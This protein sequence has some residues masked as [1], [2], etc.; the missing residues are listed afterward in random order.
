KS[1]A[2]PRRNRSQPWRPI[3]PDS[4]SGR[5][6]TPPRVGSWG[7]KFTSTTRTVYPCAFRCR[8]RGTIRPTGRSA[9]AISKSKE[10][11]T[12]SFPICERQSLSSAA[13]KLGAT[14][15]RQFADAGYF[16]AEDVLS[17]ADVERLRLSIASLPPEN[18]VK[19]RRAV[20]GARNLLEI[21]PEVRKIACD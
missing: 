2:S 12:S 3:F 11:F 10:I 5:P 20:Y 14:Y 8:P 13:D 17:E 6:A 4:R 21:C 19:R 9:A 16:I 15:V 1:T 18:E 7:T